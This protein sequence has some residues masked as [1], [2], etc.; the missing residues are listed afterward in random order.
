MFLTTPRLLLREIEES[1]WQAVLAYQSDPEFLRFTP[2]TYRTEEDVRRFVQLFLDWREEQPRQKFQFAIILQ[3]EGTFIGNC[4]IRINSSNVWEAEIGYELD[5]R[6]WRYGYATEAAQMLLAFGFRELHMH[7]IYAHCIA[8]NVASASV[9]ERLGMTCEGRL[10][11]A[12]W[13]QMRWWDCLLYAILDHEW[14]LRLD[15][16]SAT[17]HHHH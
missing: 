6:Y 8:E 12:E 7:R 15:Q 16:R 17:R 10:R 2:W 5:R 11:E 9:L 14:R 1:D 4:G 3:N 13:M